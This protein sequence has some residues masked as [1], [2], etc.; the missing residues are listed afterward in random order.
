MV[1]EQGHGSQCT[2][3]I[4][5][6]YEADKLKQETKIKGYVNTMGYKVTVDETVDPGKYGF[7]IDHESDKTH[8]FSSDDKAIIRDWM[9][10]IMKATIARDYS[11]RCTFHQGRSDADGVTEPV[12][13]SCNI[14]TIPLTVAQ[15]MN[16]APRPPSPSARAATQKAHRT[17]D[18]ETLETIGVRNINEVPHNASLVLMGLQPRTSSVE[19]TRME[20]GFSSA[21]AGKTKKIDDDDT[22]VMTPRTA[23]PPSAPPR[24][25]REVNRQSLRGISVCT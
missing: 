10:A 15:A 8:Y 7:R 9:K 25:V 21:A 12:V 4:I 11:R 23:R 3:S 19:R 6:W 17:K 13:S 2:V 5:R 16:P 20:P 22:S 18:M 14:P 1:E 24:P